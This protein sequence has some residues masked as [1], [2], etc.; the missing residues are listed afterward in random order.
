MNR[1]VS[2]ITA[3]IVVAGASVLALTGGIPGA[4][5]A[6]ASS[7]LPTMSIAMD[8]TSIA[9]GGSLESGA[10]NIVSTTTHEAQAMPTLVRLKPGASFEQAFAATAA[11]H[12]DPNY[13][14]PYGSI[15]FSAAADKGTSS[16]QTL[17]QPGDYVA[18]DTAG[19][20][21]AKW[22]HMAFTITQAGTPAALPT[23]QATVRAIE[24]GFRGPSTLHN[25]EL[26]RFQNDGFVVHMIA[27]IGVKDAK[28][29]RTMTA[30][31]EAGKDAK[32][33]RLASGYVS[34]AGPLSQGGLQ[35]Q[36]VHAKPGLYVLACFMDDQDRREHTRIGMVRTIRILK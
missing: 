5:G 34:F 1:A 31:L 7:S 25:G 16:A 22:P 14:Q 15:V 2:S 26:V 23:P 11:H 18:L 21:P 4:S 29:A 17:L 13:L 27:G 6:T 32:A 12:G 8:G 9:I 20:D 36:T 28:T 19:N 33:Q 30:L 24:F 3:V 10:V 35:Q